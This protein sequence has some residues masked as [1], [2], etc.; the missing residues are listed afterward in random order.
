MMS[1]IR[2]SFDK[3]VDGILKLYY[4]LGAI[5]IDGNRLFLI[6]G[7]CGDLR[8]FKTGLFALK[9]PLIEKIT[10]SS[11]EPDPQ[12]LRELL[13]SAEDAFLDFEHQEQFTMR[14]LVDP[15]LRNGVGDWAIHGT[16]ETEVPE[17]FL[18]PFALKLDD[19]ADLQKRLRGI[20]NTMSSVI[21]SSLSFVTELK[22]VVAAAEAK[23]SDSISAINL[24]PTME[25]QKKKLLDRIKALGDE[26]DR[27]V[28]EAE[29]KLRTI[30][31]TMSAELFAHI[32]KVTGLSQELRGAETLV[33]QTSE[34]E[35]YSRQ[36]LEGARRRLSSIEDSILN[37]T[38]K[39]HDEEMSTEELRDKRARDRKSLD[40]DRKEAAG[41]DGG[42]QGA[43]SVTEGKGEGETTLANKTSTTTAVKT[44]IDGDVLGEQVRRQDKEVE[45]LSLEIARLNVLLPQVRAEASS[46]EA[47]HTLVEEKLRSAKATLERVRKEL[48]DATKEKVLAT[49]HEQLQIAA[50]RDSI[51]EISQEYQS[52]IDTVLRQVSLIDLRLKEEEYTLI[53]LKREI[54][55]RID[56][57]IQRLTNLTKVNQETQKQLLGMR[58]VSLPLKNSEPFEI[59]VPFYIVLSRGASPRYRV[60]L[61]AY[62]SKLSKADVR[63]KLLEKNVKSAAVRAI[64]SSRVGNS[65]IG[66][67]LRYSGSSSLSFIQ[68]EGFESLSKKISELLERNVELSDWVM[69]AFL[70]SDLLAQQGFFDEVNSGLQKL[71]AEGTLHHS[72]VSE[73]RNWVLEVTA[74]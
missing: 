71:E 63:K 15:T 35:E 34:E 31:G 25:D 36:A 58:C 60:Y 47:A 57:L 49:E 44:R 17:S 11:I 72:E 1:W 56:T 5:P 59:L 42:G 14:G 74:N 48:E 40:E 65:V 21:S 66:R 67:L 23:I 12:T 18:A 29:S 16:W 26:R 52:K 2:D 28:R 73:I 43:P 51:N 13:K 9:S 50:F 46:L 64:L 10:D 8:S 32:E 7:I 39:L 69:S 27:T 30:Q 19:P 24:S 6:D 70:T 41:G 22:S 53:T 20:A 54:K 4:R 55:F 62:V 33:N 3:K 68:P 38:R 61:P 37:A 45:R